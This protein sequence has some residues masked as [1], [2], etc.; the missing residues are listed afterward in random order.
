M[1]KRQDKKFMEQAIELALSSERAGNI[2]VGALITLDDS[3]VARGFSQVLQPDYHPGRHAEILALQNVDNSLWPRAREMTCYTT[4]EPC[5]MCAGTLL[6][7]GIGRVVFGAHDVAGGAGCILDHLPSYYDEGGVYRW[8]GPLMPDVCDELYRR[9]DEAFNE[10]PVGRA[11]WTTEENLDADDYLQK[12]R[13]WLDSGAPRSGARKARAAAAEYARLSDDERIEDLLPYARAI[14]EATTTL[15]D[16]RKL[17]RYARRAGS[18][19]VFQ[20]VG[21][22]LRE[23]LPDIW[24]KKSLARGEVDEAVECWF[25]IEGH[26]RSR[27]CADQL[28][29]ATDDL[30]IELLISCRLST[31]N[32][33]IGRRQRRHYRRACAAL[34]K[35]RDELADAGSLEYW[36]FVLDDICDR[37]ESRPALLDELRRAGFIQD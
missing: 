14:F 9:A 24:I 16:F 2:P 5:V 25:E 6:L 4:L 34:R 10:L 8:D 22:T 30:E 7:H 28:V 32:Y 12:L 31:V 35:L 21:E 15:K 19:E 18:G 26:R 36:Q 3:I 13:L 17:E 23:H 1:T 27:H 33:L 37:Y 20:K 11:S 29:R